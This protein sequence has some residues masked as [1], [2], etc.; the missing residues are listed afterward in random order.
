M[1]DPQLTQ[2]EPDPTKRYG[3]LAALGTGTALNASGYFSRTLLLYLYSFTL[4]RILGADGLGIYA[5]A[6]SIVLLGAQFGELGMR[7]A[8]MRFVGAAVGTDNHARAASVLR[9]ALLIA[10]IF[11]TVLTAVLWLSAETV[12]ST[13]FDKPELTSPLRIMLPGIVLVALTNILAAF[14][15]AFRI[16]KYKVIVQ[17][18]A[19]LLLQLGLAVT[20]LYAGF[21]V[22]GAILAYLGAAL[23]AM[24]LLA[25]FANQLVPAHNLQLS[26]PVPIQ[27]MFQYS[28]PIFLGNILA[29]LSARANLLLLGVFTEN[30]VVGVFELVFQISLVGAMFLTSFNMVFA[31]IVADL[32]SRKRWV[33][34]QDLY[35]TAT[36]WILTMA[37]PVFI[38]LALLAGPLL[39]IFGPDFLAGRDALKVLAVAQLLNIAVGSVGYLLTMSGHPTAATVNSAIGLALTIGLNLWLV[40]R[41]GLLGA[42]IAQGAMLATVNLLGLIEVRWLL[43]LQPYTSTYRKPLLAGAL[44]G[45]VGFGLLRFLG[46]IQ[47]G[48]TML[49]WLQL[50]MV[51]LVVVSTYGAA[52]LLQGL[53]VSDRELLTAVYHR[54]N[55]QLRPV[56]AD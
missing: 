56:I 41:W 18:V 36:R 2:P 10:F 52:L 40:P 30:Q 3:N 32:S 47:I 24:I 7:G 16:M 25:F 5:L 9:V 31:P 28:I 23:V 46:S 34:L 44:A 29:I 53:E 38:A 11:T 49:Q 22:T 39:A 45:L 17:D 42:A 6:L 37:L 50:G 1:S 51:S 54:L 12:A 15:Q 20:L 27:E 33:E 4:A 35:Q 14:T 55:K 19:Q 43:N 13:I 21:A 8:V 48:A 26:D